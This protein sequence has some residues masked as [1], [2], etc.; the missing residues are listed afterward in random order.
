M[1]E[2]LTGSTIDF[3]GPV[4]AVLDRVAAPIPVD[5]RPV[6]ARELPLR[7]RCI[8]EFLAFS[9]ESDREGKRRLGTYGIRLRRIRRGS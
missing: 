1:Q 8:I 7:T 5:A 3:V 9:R 2:G 4:R 6:P